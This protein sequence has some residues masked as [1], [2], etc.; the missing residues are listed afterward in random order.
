MNGGEELKST[1][2]EKGERKG[3]ER[4]EEVEREEGW[5][6]GEINNK[7]RI[8]KMKAEICIQLKISVSDFPDHMVG[9]FFFFSFFPLELNLCRLAQ[10][11]NVT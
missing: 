2:K 3:G 9:A 6:R 1:S 11:S 7:A 4:D 5:K 10:T 8:S